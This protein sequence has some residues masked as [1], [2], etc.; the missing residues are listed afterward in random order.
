MYSCTRVLFLYFL[1]KV[2]RE[3][4]E[5]LALSMGASFVETSAKFGL[6]VSDAFECLAKQAVRRIVEVHSGTSTGARGLGPQPELP[7]RASLSLPVADTTSAR[8]QC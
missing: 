8:G 2:T 5:S 1:Q 4:G 6:G 7:P 3:E